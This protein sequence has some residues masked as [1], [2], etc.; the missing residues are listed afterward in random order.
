MDGSV[1]SNKKEIRDLAE[2]L[3]SFTVPELCDGAQEDISMDWRIK[4]QVGADKICGPAV[5][6]DVPSGE[7]DL[8]ADAILQLQE[9]DVLVVAGKGN[10]SCS[11]WGDLRSICASRKRA[12]GVVIDGAFRDV[13]GCREAGFPVFA[14]GLTGKT[15]AKT[16]AGAIQVPVSCGGI[17][18]NP[19]DMIVGDPNG[20]VVIPPEKAEKIM[21][22]ALD[23]RMRQEAVIR[24]MRETG[25]VLPKVPKQIN[26]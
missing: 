21:E 12:A 25:E 15:A 16:G 20:V 3:K 26:N 23:K 18:V 4:P 1:K 22:R 8:V 9:G 17:S 6:V 13:E 2:R 19:G 14:K 11:Y 10:C 24:R 5:T 7:G